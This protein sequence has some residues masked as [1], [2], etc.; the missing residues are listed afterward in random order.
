MPGF[1]VGNDGLAIGGH[2]D[3]SPSASNEYYYSYTWEI[4]GLLYDSE[5]SS[6]NSRT[7][8][9]HNRSEGRNILVNVKELTL[10]TFTVNKEM[11][12][13]NSLEYKYAKSVHW[14]DIRITWYD[15][16]GLI[17]II[18]T[19]RESVWHHDDG[20]RSATKYKRDSI[21]A[22]FLPHD[23]D[24]RISYYCHNSWPSMIK[25][26]DLT[27]TQSDVKVVEISLTYD[28]AEEQIGDGVQ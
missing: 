17:G 20:I 27:Y 11:V 14:E 3:H 6:D 26:G 23:Y 8:N 7:A 12:Q 22:Q 13:G 18:K 9:A 16:K 2:G 21:V 15:V 19:W 28:W 4:T 25:Y 24:S 5:R 1:V 10:P